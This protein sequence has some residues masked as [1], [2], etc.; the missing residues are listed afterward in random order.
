MIGKISRLDT[1][2]GNVNGHQSHP[3][4]PPPPELNWDMWLGPAPYRDYVAHD[5]VHTGY[6]HNGIHYLFRWISDFSGGKMTD[7]GAHHNDFAQWVLDADKSGPVKVQG[8]GEFFTDGPWDV[9]REFDVQYTYANGVE[10]H[11]HSGG[12][13]GIKITGSDGF[14]F[15]SRG[16][17]EMQARGKTYSDNR[18]KIKAGRTPGYLQGVQTRRDGQE[19]LRS[20]KRQPS[21]QLA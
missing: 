8:K 7:W 21:R 18:E 16:R 20:A 17:I 11:C 3:A 12:E 4:S 9:A 15:V 2:I 6:G 19:D 14:I 10:V 13:N 5:P 1:H